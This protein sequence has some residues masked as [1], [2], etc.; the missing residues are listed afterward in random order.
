MVVSEP[1]FDTSGNRDTCAVTWRLRLGR[2]N[3][4]TQRTA[5][6]LQQRRNRTRDEIVGL[7]R[8]DAWR[9]ADLPDVQNVPES[10]GE[11]TIE[12]YPNGH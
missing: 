2:G 6:A 5:G 7:S 11:T 10:H 8:D 1:A 12:T 3:E 9:Q 4:S